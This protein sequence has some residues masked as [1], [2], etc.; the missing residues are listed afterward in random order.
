[1]TELSK[2]PVADR[3]E[4][5]ALLPYVTVQHHYWRQVLMRK[6]KIIRLKVM[7]FVFSLML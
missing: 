5:N 3:A 2:K 4:H 6:R 7:K 1:M